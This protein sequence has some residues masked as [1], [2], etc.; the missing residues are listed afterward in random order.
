MKTQEPITAQHSWLWRRKTA[1]LLAGLVVGAIG[2]G[3]SAALMPPWYDDACHWLVA[4]TLAHT[5]ETAFPLVSDMTHTDPDS[6]FVTVGPAVNYPVAG[7]MAVFG[8]DFRTVRIL[9][10]GLAVG[11][12]VALFMLAR[13][14]LHSAKAVWAVILLSGSV[15]FMT[16]GSQLLGEGPMLL[17]L[18]LG[19]WA[20]LRNSEIRWCDALLAALA[21]NL[22]ILSK[23]YIALPLGLTVLFGFVHALVKHEE[24]WYKYLAIGLLL[25]IGVALHYNLR[26]DS[27]MTLTLTGP[28]KAPTAASS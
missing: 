26:F 16:F 14:V 21:F 19:L 8:D 13:A 25:P 18:L 2:L 23:E 27:W 1:L 5:G 20:L 4:R 6:R 24:S 11:V 22:A 3:L 10:S 15:P 28:P 7:W 12:L 17:Y 9:M